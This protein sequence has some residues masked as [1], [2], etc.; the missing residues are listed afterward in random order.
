MV[1]GPPLLIIIAQSL[2]LMKTAADIQSVWFWFLNLTSSSSFAPPSLRLPLTNSLMNI[3]GKRGDLFFFFSRE[4]DRIKKEG[5]K[6]SFI[7]AWAEYYFSQTLSQTLSQTQLD[8]IA[9][10]QTIICRQLFAGHMV[11]SRPMKKK[12]NLRW[13]ITPSVSCTLFYPAVK[14]SV[15]IWCI[16]L[17]FLISIL[18]QEDNDF[19]EGIRA[20]N[21]FISLTI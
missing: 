13:I 14:L 15:K 11:G 12:K 3:F 5:E 10:E 18:F 8:D 21:S 17:S 20:G 4:S 2:T 7:Y 16:F 1:L 9:H 19:Y 6:H